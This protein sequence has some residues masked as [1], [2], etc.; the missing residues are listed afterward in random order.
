MTRT[1]AGN[2]S[3]TLEALRDRIRRLAADNQGHV[4]AL[5]GGLDADLVV[6]FTG[7]EAERQPARFT[8][9]EVWVVKRPSTAH[10]DGFSRDP[11]PMVTANVHDAL[12]LL[13]QALPGWDFALRTHGDDLAL[14]LW[15]PGAH[16]EGPPTA[17]G[18]VSGRRLLA[19]A[20]CAGIVEGRMCPI[21]V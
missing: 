4:L 19:M 16:V 17:T 11:C 2:D 3:L 20:V 5:D 10:G 13:G 8:Q 21:R 15:A 9:R 7:D 14:D 18:G 12:I 1:I 6:A